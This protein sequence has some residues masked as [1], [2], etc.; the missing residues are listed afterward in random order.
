MKKKSIAS[1]IMRTFLKALGVMALLIAVGFVGYFLTMLFYNITSRSER[2]TQYSHVIDVTTGTDSRNLIFSYDEKSMLIN[3]IVLEIYHSDTNNMDYVTIPSGTTIEVSGKTYTEMLKASQEVPQIVRLSRL[4]K[5][6]TGDVAYEY[7]IMALEEAT[8]TDIGY[9]TAMKSTKFEELFVNRGT[10]EEAYYA[11]SQKMLDEV[12]KC[13]DSYDL[14]DL[15][16]DY[17]SDM[18]CNITCAQKTQYAASFKKVKPEQIHTYR[19]VADQVKHTYTITK[20]KTKALLRS[21]DSN[22]EYTQADE[23]SQT[24]ASKTTTKSSKT[25]DSKKLK[26]QLTN[27]SQ[28]N[29]L[30]A[31]YKEKMESAGYTIQGTGNYLGD[32][33]TTTTIL[34]KKKSQ[35]KDLLTYFK[36]GKIQVT[37]DE[38]TDGADIEVIIGSEDRITGY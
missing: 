29:G 2:S 15:I 27:A 35:G 12:A 5:Y 22:E 30:A 13:Q 34:V 33:Q 23:R 7:G 9:F 24:A 20:D 17:W 16:E 36:S 31:S 11:P 14:S 1:V 21:L 10:K 6:F 28:I 3:R 26:I 8:G 4:N 38:L 19:V 37:S 18:I 25:G 32:M